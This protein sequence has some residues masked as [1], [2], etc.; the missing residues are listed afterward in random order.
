MEV[1]ICLL[2]TGVPALQTWTLTPAANEVGQKQTQALGKT[3]KLPWEQRADAAVACGVSTLSRETA[4]SLPTV[5]G[6][7]SYFAL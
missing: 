7:L 5:A 3:T 4:I 6:E 2:G 1:G